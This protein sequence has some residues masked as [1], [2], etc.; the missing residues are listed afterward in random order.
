MWICLYAKVGVG[1]EKEKKQNSELWR[2]VGFLPLLQTN[3][4]PKDAQVSDL[5]HLP[6]NQCSTSFLFLSASTL[7]LYLRKNSHCLWRHLWCPERA[8]ILRL[9]ISKHFQN[10]KKKNDFQACVKFCPLHMRRNSNKKNDFQAYVEDKVQL[11][12]QLTQQML[13]EIY[14][15]LG[16][17]LGAGDTAVNVTKFLLFEAWEKR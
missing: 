5:L 10:K 12:C 4:T 7:A 17:V 8:P 15:M 13:V 14:Y 16:T 3:I 11:R 1:K 2:K 9:D 6:I